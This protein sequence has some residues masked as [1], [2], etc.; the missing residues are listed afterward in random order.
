MTQQGNDKPQTSIMLKVS[1]VGLRGA[2]FLALVGLLC[3]ILLVVILLA[4]DIKTSNDIVA[5]VG[6]FT[7]VLGS[8][9]GLIVGNGVGSQGREAS[10][11]RADAAQ[12]QAT[13]ANNRVATTKAVAGMMQKKLDKRAPVKGVGV[14]PERGPEADFADLSDMVKQILEA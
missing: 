3:V 5:I 13:D 9:V 11:K 1:E 7:S 2:I 6:V 14:A 4:F 8:L 12:Q 10:D